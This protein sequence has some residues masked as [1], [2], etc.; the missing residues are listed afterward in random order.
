LPAAE[1]SDREVRLLRLRAQ[2]LLEPRCSSLEEVARRCLC[3]QAQDVPTARFALRA[4]TNGL[5]AAGLTESAESEP[6]CRSWLMRNTIHLF[7]DEDLAWMRPLLAPTVMKPAE[8][9]LGQLGAADKL[10][11]ALSA[12]RRRLKQGTLSREETRALLARCGIGPGPEGE[13]NAPFYWTVHAAA[14]GG[15]LV[16]RPAL[17]PKG[18]FGAAPPGNDSGESGW[19]RLAR[20]Y[21]EAYGPATVRDFAYWGKVKVSDARRGWEQVDDTVEVSTAH[22]PMTALSHLLDPPVAAE[23]SIRLLGTWD[24]YMLGH[25]GRVLSVRPGHAERLPLLAGYQCAIADGVVFAGWKL[26]RGK[27]QLTVAVKPFGR[28][29]KSARDGLEREAADVG[30]FL[31]AEVKLRLDRS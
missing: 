4:R 29:P 23:Y 10:P 19:G 2:E 12:V 3:I 8:R 18:P 5:T 20:R 28:L 30:R 17:D 11:K 25:K 15:S 6:V 16:M 1:L 14:L 24:N 9:R 13:V 26:E 7:A 27:G 31:E 21:L 22:G